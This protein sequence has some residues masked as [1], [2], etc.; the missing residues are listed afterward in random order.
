MYGL[1]VKLGSI[2]VGLFNTDVLYRVSLCAFHLCL[3]Q[4][5]KA[6]L[7][8]LISPVS[9]TMNLAFPSRLNSF[10]LLPGAFL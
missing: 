7:T 4:N 8:A 10:S 5:K 9:E 1:N 2:C 6:T 3:C